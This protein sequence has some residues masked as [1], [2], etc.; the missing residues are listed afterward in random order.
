MNDLA[1]FPSGFASADAGAPAAL[2][3]R[4]G[5]RR[6]ELDLPY[7]GAVTPPEAFELAQQGLARLVDV[8]T[9]PE[10]RFVGHAIGAVNV[11]WHGRDAAP[12]AAFVHELRKVAPT[13]AALLLICR[14]GVRSHAAAVAARM[15]GFACVY[16]V[17]EGF[18]GQIDPARQRGK[19]NGWRWHG[20]PWE[21]D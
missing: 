8:R 17:L 19:I 18:E 9:A 21:Q 3:D 5:L 14:S 1:D 20:L 4:A 12:R 10:F 13:D 6:V 2:F 11:E 7:A 15:A 16:N